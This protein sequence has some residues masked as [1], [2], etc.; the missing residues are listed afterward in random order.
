MRE[1]KSSG[2]ELP[3]A[4]KVA[5]ATSS[6]SCR[7]WHRFRRRHLPLITITTY[8]ANHY[9]R[10]VLS[11]PSRSLI[12]LNNY[13]AKNYK[14]GIWSFSSSSSIR[15]FFPVWFPAHLVIRCINLSHLLSKCHLLAIMKWLLRG[16]FILAAALYIL[17]GLA[18]AFALFGLVSR[19]L[20]EDWVFLRSWLESSSIWTCSYFCLCTWLALLLTSEIFSREGTKKSSQTMARA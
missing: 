11:L 16:L 3:A 12:K 4:M 1:V 19:I 13:T 18:N 7:F 20:L 2:A 10:A 5:P 17:G 6:L 14:W 9:K 15:V 8:K